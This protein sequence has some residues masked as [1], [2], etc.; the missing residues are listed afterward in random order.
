[1]KDSNDQLCMY[2]TTAHILCYCPALC[3]TLIHQQMDFNY[4]FWQYGILFDFIWGLEVWI[5]LSVLN[6]KEEP[7]LHIPESV[8]HHPA[9]LSF[10]SSVCY[11]WSKF[12]FVMFVGDNVYF[13][14][15]SYPI[16]CTVW[17]SKSNQVFSSGKTDAN[18]YHDLIYTLNVI[19]CTMER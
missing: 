8:V 18:C 2:E 3:R 1:M 12:Y 4:L 16:N 14:V 5:F 19:S 17:T 15:N 6:T 13:H 10:F 7:P 9:F 11:P